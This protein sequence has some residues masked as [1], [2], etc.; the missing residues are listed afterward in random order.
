[1]LCQS[2]SWEQ[3]WQFEKNFPQIDDQLQ[4]ACEI[5]S[6]CDCLLLFATQHDYEWETHKHWWID[7]CTFKDGEDIKSNYTWWKGNDFDV[8]PILQ[9][10]DIL[11][12]NQRNAI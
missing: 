9:V 4:F 8:K 10:G 12:V 7:V 6:R 3:L 1:M 11:G 5:P 2:C